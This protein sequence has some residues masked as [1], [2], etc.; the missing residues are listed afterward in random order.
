MWEWFHNLVPPFQTIWELMSNLTKFHYY[1]PWVNKASD[2]SVRSE[3]C[4]WLYTYV[5]AVYLLLQTWDEDLQKQQHQVYSKQTWQQQN[6]WLQSKYWDI[7]TY[8]SEDVQF[9]SVSEL[10]ITIKWISN[11]TSFDQIQHYLANFFYQKLKLK[12]YRHKTMSITTCPSIEKAE[13]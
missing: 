9:S 6:Q 1:L 3:A 8:T 2:W 7:Y 12:S 5:Y 13:A 11:L 4:T 10:N